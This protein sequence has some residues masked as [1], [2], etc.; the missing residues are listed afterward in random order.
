MLR[1]GDIVG[2]KVFKSKTTR[3]GEEKLVKLGKVHMA[4][5]SPDGTTV[6]GFTVK[7][8]DIAGMVKRPDFFMA[9]DAFG[10]VEKGLL[11]KDEKDGVDDRARERL[12]IDWDACIMWTGMDAKTSDGRELGYVNNAIFDPKNGAVQK[13]CVGDG[14]VAQSL[15]GSL[16]IPVSMVQGYHKGYMIVDPA[17]ADLKLSGGAAAAAGEGY[18]KAKIAGKKAGE[19]AGA[20]A[21]DAIDKGSFALGKALGKAKR[22]IDEA[23]AENEAEQQPQEQLPAREAP[24]VQVSAPKPAA[25][26]AGEKDGSAKPEPKTYVPASQAEG[27]AGAATQTKPVAKAAPKPAAKGSS[28]PAA[29]KKPAPKSGSEEAA[30]AVGRELGKMGSMFG[31]FIDEYKKASK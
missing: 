31:S 18:A 11:L 12:G 1:V 7:R 23:K 4:V 5:F 9:R 29:K 15:V 27:A 13:F 14:S 19:K 2:L 17:A 3:K 22:A 8:P 10:T 20:V 24:N 6:V 28:R 30:K 21:A 16:E 26:I 25:R